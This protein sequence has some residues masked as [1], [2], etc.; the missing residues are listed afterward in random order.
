MVA[1]CGY[2]RFQAG[3]TD[4]LDTDITPG[5]KLGQPGYLSSCA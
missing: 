2:F 3:K 1:A 4:G 5:L